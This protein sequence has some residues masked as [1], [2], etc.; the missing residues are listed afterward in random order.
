MATIGLGTVGIALLTAVI[1]TPIVIAMKGVAFASRG[2]SVVF[3][4]IC[5]EVS[6]HPRHT[7]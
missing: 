7:C 6:Y 4:L 1:A 3:N 5:D 2:I